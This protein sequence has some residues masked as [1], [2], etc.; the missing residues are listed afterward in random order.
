MNSYK[1]SS[2]KTPQTCERGR[3]MRTCRKGFLSGLILALAIM[4]LS[5]AFAATNVTGISHSGTADGGVEI[6]IKISGD[7]PQVGAF[8]MEDPARMLL[9]V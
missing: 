5:A 1:E 9:G 8:A 3:S 7:V 2:L 4:P 6:A